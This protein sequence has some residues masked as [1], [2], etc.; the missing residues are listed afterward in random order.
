VDA[1]ELR[2]LL[3]ANIRAAA[4]EKGVALNSLADFAGVSRAQLYSVLA[5]ETSPTVDWLAK[6]AKPLGHEAWE[7][8]VTGRGRPAGKRSR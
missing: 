2:V 7:L 4:K 3:A 5:G 6:V 1:P 8:L